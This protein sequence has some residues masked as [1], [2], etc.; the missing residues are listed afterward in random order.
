MPGSP[1]APRPRVIL[2]PM[3]IL[4]GASLCRSAWASVLQAMNST[5]IISAR[6]IRLMALLPPPPIPM[7]RISAKFSESDRSGIAFSSGW[8]IR[9]GQCRWP[10]RLA[11]R[12]AGTSAEYRPPGGGC[13]CR[14]Q[15]RWCAGAPPA[16]PDGGSGEQAAQP[17]PQ[18]P[19][20]ATR[21]RPLVAAA[22]ALGDGPGTPHEQP[23]GG[24]EGRREEVVHESADARRRGHANWHLEH[25]AAE[26]GDAGELGRAAGEDQPGGQDA[27]VAGGRDLL[28]EF[29]EELPHARV[30]DGADL[31]PL[32]GAAALVAE[33]L[34]VDELLG[35]DRAQGARAV[36]ELQG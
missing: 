35:L 26:F 6:I 3:R 14:S 13:G 20:Y 31:R 22:V 18:A 30:D 7:T 34:D 17:L 23:D 9:V 15:G 32:D 5:P 19:Q 8:L 12:T 28:A 10:S 27:A 24:R 25:V 36:S 1:P 16:G 11:P 4:C 21:G 2:S 29:L 33:R